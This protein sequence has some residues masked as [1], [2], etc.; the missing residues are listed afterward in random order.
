MHAEE[1]QLTRQVQK[2]KEAEEVYAG[3]IEKA[4]SRERGA[5]ASE[6]A[7]FQE[8]KT[9]ARQAAAAAAAAANSVAVATTSELR[10]DGLISEL[11]TVEQ[12]SA[13]LNLTV[14]ELRV[15]LQEGQEVRSEG[16][17]GPIP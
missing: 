1:I 2:I 16:R 4:R 12:W 10:G 13:A 5:A 6:E 3:L 14:P 8:L 17:R 11:A 15:L 9:N 7:S